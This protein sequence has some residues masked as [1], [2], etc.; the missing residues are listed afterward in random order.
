MNLV[1]QLKSTLTGDAE[2]WH[3]NLHVYH[4]LDSTPYDHLSGRNVYR[5]WLLIQKSVLNALNGGVTVA[6]PKSSGIDAKIRIF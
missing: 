2:D 5:D 3:I 1:T 6:W 4:P